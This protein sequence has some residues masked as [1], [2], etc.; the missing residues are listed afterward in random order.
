MT[1]KKLKKLAIVSTHPIQY[2]APLFRMLSLRG[3]IL[4][5]VFYT[6]G[7]LETG[8]KY[9]PG[10]G[11]KVEWDIPLLEGYAYTFVQN[12]SPQ[13]GS[14]HFAGIDNPSLVT[15]LERWEP[16]AILIFGWCF[17]SHL[18]A[19]RHFKGKKQILFRGDS[20]LLDE[21]G[22][23][24]LKKAAR[25]IFLTWVYR[26]IDKALYVGT[27]N[28]E[29]YLTHGLKN[30]Q[31]VFAPHAID[32]DRFMAQGVG[33]KVEEPGISPGTVV[34]IFAGKFETKKDPRLL[35]NT[36]LLLPGSNAHLLMV[37]NGELE[38]A[39][40]EIAG[41]QPAEISSRIHFLPFQNQFKM[42]EIY[43]MGHVLVL[44]SQG[45]G[46]TWGLSVNEAMACSLALLVSDK[47]GCAVDLVEPGMNGYVFRS[48]DGNDLLKKME[49]LLSDQAG[50]TVMGKRSLQI[51]R[52]WSFENI[53]MAVE[54]SIR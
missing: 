25:R 18:K 47:C 49:K 28:K 29:Y 34:F 11:K 13:P 35:L 30:T 22:G 31:L 53:C 27:A 54:Q 24:S 52:S 1:I 6:W 45:P 2:N 50:L 44:P 23:P 5:K 39:L 26:H 33:G 46:E 19:L 17:K 43:R 21:T 42:P 7:Q 48:R 16:D 51:I 12:I 37:G 20:N 3:I 15:E 4:P 8:E 14:H 41:R 40:K 32:N 36:F 9:D 38:P 10:F